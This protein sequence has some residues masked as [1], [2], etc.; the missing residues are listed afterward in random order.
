MLNSSAILLVPGAMEEEVT[1]L[2]K[3]NKDTAN[4]ALHLFSYSQL[5]IQVSVRCIRVSHD[6]LFRIIWVVCTLPVYD[7]NFTTVVAYN[8]PS[9]F[10][11]QVRHIVVVVARKITGNDACFYSSTRLKIDQ[12]ILLDFTLCRMAGFST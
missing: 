5:I 4:V 12:R 6:L 8:R 2:A 9:L 3:V 10:V 11:W 1:V 7:N